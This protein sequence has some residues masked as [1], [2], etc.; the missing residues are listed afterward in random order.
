MYGD[1]TALRD[2]ARR[3][4]DRAEE[5][6]RSAARLERLIDGVAWEGLAADAMRHQTGLQLRALGHAAQLHDDAAHALLRH[7][8]E[9]Q[10]LQ[11]LIAVIERRVA[12]LIDAARSRIAA[13][14]RGLID[15][16]IG[17]R[18]DPVDE[19]LDRFRPPPPGHR[20]WLSVRLPGL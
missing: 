16:L 8:R 15:G 2:L 12:G 11:D 1:A 6:R 18:P 14:G 3:L 20:D 10:R 9:V 17:R 7:A 19:L 4:S 13:V 5:I